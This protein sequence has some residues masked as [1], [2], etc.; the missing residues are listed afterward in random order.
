MFSTMSAP[1]VRDSVLPRF[2]RFLQA[3]LAF[4]L[5]V[6][7]WGAFVRASGSGAGCGEHWPLCNGT[8]VPVAPTFKTLVELSHR[9]TSG[10]ALLLVVGGYVWTRRRLAS[11]DPV[12][13]MMLGAVVFMILEALVGAGLVKFGLV[14]DDDSTARAVVLAIHLVNTFTLLA[15]LALAAWYA[16]GA[17]AGRWQ[18]SRTGWSALGILAATLLIGITG[19]IAALGDTLFP[20]DS[21]REGIAQDFSPTA[22]LLLRLRILHPTFA[23]LGGTA[24]LAFAYWHLLHGRSVRTVRTARWAGALVVIQWVAG[25]TNLLLLAPVWLQLVHLVLADLVWLALVVLGAS[26]LADEAA[27]PAAQTA[28]AGTLGASPASAVAGR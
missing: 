17:P 6:V 3:T 22:H 18:R 14:A 16:G 21:L 20:A 24:A 27:A 12:R 19:A 5:L 15:F 13:R 8:V 1:A 2:A 4:N 9:A 7:A 11:G 25:T 23:V 10:I 26:A 28:P